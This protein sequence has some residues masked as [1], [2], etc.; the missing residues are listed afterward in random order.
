M[1][2]T[3]LHGVYDAMGEAFARHAFSSTYNLLYDQPVVRSLIPDVNGKVVLDV[4]CGPGTY[5][6]WLLEG[7]AEVIGVD[8][9]PTMIDIAAR[10]FGRRVRLHV[11]EAPQ[12]FRFLDDGEIDVAISAL[13]I[14]YVRDPLPLL[15]ELA[16]VLAP[17]GALILS[18]TH[19]TTDWVRKGGSYFD[20][21]LETD[22]W[23]TDGEEHEVRFWRMPL[24]SLT[25][26]FFAA[27]F[28]IERLV[29]HRPSVE[30]A[31]ADPAE[32]EKLVRR[33]GFIAFRLRPRPVG[34]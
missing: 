3:P 6:G 1:P 10:R 22:L 9:S 25:D 29:E 11:H 33:P 2:E 27:G 4:G 28:V 26:A 13:M 16:R 31:E 19:P 21:A 30:L 8:A 12:P 5:F 32:F 24:Q 7:G 17:N 23:T 34:W 20:T 18:T 15:Q 14:H